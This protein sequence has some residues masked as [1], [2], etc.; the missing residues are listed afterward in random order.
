M[1]YEKINYPVHQAI[2]MFDNWP[3]PWTFYATVAAQLTPEQGLYFSQCWAEVM[4]AVH[5][6]LPYLTLCA[7]QAANA[8]QEKYAIEEAVAAMLAR[9]AAYQWR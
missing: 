5:W 3:Q 7:Q 6:Q 1:L 9:A 4:H 2:A 8:V